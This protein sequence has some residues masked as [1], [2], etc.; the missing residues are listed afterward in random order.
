MLVVVMLGVVM[1]GAVIP[2]VVALTTHFSPKANPPI[3]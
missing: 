3:S 1:L 2:S